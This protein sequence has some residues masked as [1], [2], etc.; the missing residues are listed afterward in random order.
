[1]QSV[2]FPDSPANQEEGN[3]LEVEGAAVAEAKRRR[4]AVTSDTS[5]LLQFSPRQ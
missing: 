5:L 3:D 1:M 2:H 4:S